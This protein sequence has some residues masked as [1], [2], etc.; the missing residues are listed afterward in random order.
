M[1]TPTQPSSCRAREGGYSNSAGLLRSA[2]ISLLA[3]PNSVAAGD[4][5]VQDV[6]SQRVSQQATGIVAAMAA[7]VQLRRALLQV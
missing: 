1:I 7:D 2:G 6:Q 3:P 4:G 5:D